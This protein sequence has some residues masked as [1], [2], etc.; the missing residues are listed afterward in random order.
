[1]MRDLLVP[2]RRR[3]KPTRLSGAQSE[4]PLVPAPVLVLGRSGFVD[5][6][7]PGTPPAPAPVESTQVRS[8]GEKQ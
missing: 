4:A 5:G 8:T 1:M 6:H 2:W 3:A 7:S